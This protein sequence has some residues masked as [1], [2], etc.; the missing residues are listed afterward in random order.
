MSKKIRIVYD[1]Q[2]PACNQY[3]VL[4]EKYAEREVELIDARD[5]SA[6]MDEITERGLDID[7]GMVVEID[8]ELHYGADAIH[9]LAAIGPRTGVFNVV[10]RLFFQNARAAR[11]L[12]PVLRRFRNFLLKVL[13]VK[14]INNLGI[15][16]RDKF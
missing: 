3:C 1:K 2:C 8:G 5:V 11:V 7:D 6:L 15:N 9:V 16:G 13:G 10:N 4:A 14:R 12:Y